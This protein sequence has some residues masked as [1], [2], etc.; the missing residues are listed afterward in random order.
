MT[1]WRSLLPSA[2]MHSPNLSFS[3]NCHS[4]FFPSPRAQCLPQHGGPS[5]QQHSASSGLRQA[6]D[7][8]AVGALLPTSSPLRPQRRTTPEECHPAAGRVSRQNRHRFGF[9]SLLGCSAF[10]G[11]GAKSEWK[12]CC[13]GLIVLLCLMHS[14]ACTRTHT[15]AHTDSAVAFSVYEFPLCR[16]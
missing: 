12:V 8:A 14:R 5:S 11:R 16:F 15:R 7:P 6:A 3:F 9:F 13:I 4:V 10:E 1:T 2:W